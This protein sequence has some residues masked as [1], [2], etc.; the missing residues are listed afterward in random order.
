[1]NKIRKYIFRSALMLAAMSVAS[2][3]DE[4]LVDDPNSVD[5][6]EE[7]TL[8]V[9]VPD[10]QVTELSTRA[11]EDAVINSLTVFCYDASN[12][13]LQ[14]QT[15][16][17]G[18]TSKGNGTFTVKVPIHKQTRKVHLVA[19]AQ[20]SASDENPSKIF[21][22][23]AG[24]TP[25]LWG[26]AELKDLLASG[27]KMTMIRQ[28]AKVS[29]S[30]KASN[31]TV[32]QF[33]VF[34][35]ANSGSLAPAGWTLTPSTPTVS[36]SVA[37]TMES[38]MK[39]ASDQVFIFETP[40]ETGS[41][42]KARIIIKAKYQG[43]EGYYVVAF[44]NR[45]GSGKSDQPGA[46]T[47]TPID[48]IRNHHYI[49]NITEVRQAGWATLDQAKKAQPDNRLTVQI[50][51]NCDD[52]FDIIAS[53][54][55][56]LGV[57]DAV[58]VPYNATSATINVVTSYPGDGTSTKPYS[59]SSA[60]SW[61]ITK[62]ATDVESTVS[63]VT[64]SVN[65]T[66][67]KYTVKV[68]L[69]AN[70]QSSQLRVG[71]VVVKSGNLTRTVEIR[72]AGRDYMRDPNRK[73]KVSG[74]PGLSTVYQNDWFAF[75]DNV[76]KGMKEADNYVGGACDQGLHFPAVPA[77]TATYTIPKL[78]GDKS[79]TVTSGGS[80]FSV[81][82]SG[83]NYVVKLTNTAAGIAKGEL[84]IVNS[85]NATI[86][87]DLYKT[88]YIHQLTS[89]T[90]S[91]QRDGGAITGWFYYGVSKVGNRFILDRNL[92]SPTNAPYI[93]TYAGFSGYESAVGAYFKVSTTKSSEI[94]NPL[95][96]ISSLSVSK[97]KI[98]SEDEVSAWN[99]RVQNVS[100][101][102]GEAAMVATINDANGKKVYIPH[103]GYYEADSHKYETH[104]NIWTRTLLSGTQGFDVK[105]PEFGYWYR[106]LNVYGNSV[107]YGQMRFAN[108]SG[109]QVPTSTSVYKFMPIRLIWQ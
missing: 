53:R 25:V 79:A 58:E 51:D 43:Q 11:N 105:S 41:N 5:A 63:G 107:G 37:Y 2:C 38:G 72:Q 80:V 85:D 49:V 42:P 82:T 29:V 28:T 24:A 89:S 7:L 69:W 71:T 100:G 62:N 18:W 75:V 27:T 56:E 8:D 86:S 20:V 50:T 34:N 55:Y 16:T 36:S 45:A 90:A 9:A 78:A 10:W 81:T 21:T 61:I 57:S 93:I 106:F 44:R 22:T 30:N 97:F 91:L 4:N 95:T 109:G 88:G 60:D 59:I 64:Q 87:Y 6:P 73:V 96:I 31:F 3:A 108:G 40:K 33:G 15:L 70:S 32:S 65:S 76:C 19:N 66:S 26:S 67:K 103:G 12:K 13:H 68:P 47:Y 46:Y 92:G 102:T 77:Y 101:T 35:T 48:V 14:H 23:M 83:N 52:I 39:G 84:R 94:N 54:D 1:M 99:V 17:S 104:A 98:P 74:I